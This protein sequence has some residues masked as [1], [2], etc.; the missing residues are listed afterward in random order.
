MDAEARIE[1][2]AEDRQRGA[3]EIAADA[4][5][6]LS[7]LAD[8]SRDAVADAGIALVEAHPAMA[9][10]FN[11]V[12]GALLGWDEE[13]PA[14]LDRLRAEA[15]ARR[16][17]LIAQVADLADDGATVA[18]YSR[19]GTVVAGLKQAAADRTVR[20]RVGEGR[21]GMEGLSVARDLDAAG[22]EVTVTTD[23][24]LVSDLDDVDLVL[25]GADAI[26]AEG[27]VNKVGT[28]ALLRSADADD[29]GVVV[30]CGSDKR[31]P[32]AWR[33]APPLDRQ[34]TLDV[35]VPEGVAVE[36]PLFEVAPLDPVTAIVT[37]DGPQPPAM[38]ADG[39]DR[40]RVHPRLQEVGDDG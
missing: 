39:L 11:L 31:L 32:S 37:E 40:M 6:L 22:A 35:D 29:V 34:G 3:S 38:V 12:N 4:R 18:T 23:A 19:S 5:D 17:D 10:L 13:G 14:V 24:A 8:E 1:T 28:S 7:S 36:A 15:D 30:A 16:R 33:R 25:V 20:V 27:L 9:P 26:C 2:L 21:P